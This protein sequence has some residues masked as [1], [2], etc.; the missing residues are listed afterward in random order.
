MQL[1]GTPKKSNNITTKINDYTVTSLDYSVVADA[2]N[3]SVTITLPASPKT[4]QEFNISC[5]NSTYA[6]E[7]DFNG[8]NFYDSSSN[9]KLFKGENLTVHYNGTVWVGV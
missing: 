2:T 7:I 8:K 4:G 3:N 5:L 9:E 1:K 6:V